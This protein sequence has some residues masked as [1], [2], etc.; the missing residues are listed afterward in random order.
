MSED[1]LKAIWKASNDRMHAI[2]LNSINLNTMNQA[3]K[4]F[5]NRISRRN[6]REINIAIIGIL[7]FS[8]I[9]YFT[10]EPLKKMGAILL[11]CYAISVIYYIRKPK[12]KQPRFDIT[13][14]IRE[15]LLDYQEYVMEERKLLKNVFYW[16]L[17]PM[18][19]G[20]TLF[21]LDWIWPA[22]LIYFIG[23]LLLSVCVYNLNQ[24]K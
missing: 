9:A 24:P 4:R 23:M 3:M 14:S 19:P 8:M 12:E 21:T 18:F 7:I 17:L 5:E 22:K 6:T 11:I 16:Y 1:E 15:Q 2:N 10:A 13:S 20:L